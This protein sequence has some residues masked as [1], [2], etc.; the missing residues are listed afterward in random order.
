MEISGAASK[1]NYNAFFTKNENDGNKIFSEILEKKNHSNMS[2]KQ[3]LSTLTP[4]EL[5]TIQKA[6]GLANSIRVNILSGEGAENLFLRP[7]GTDK[8]VDLNNDGVV[9]IGEGKGMF[10]PPPNA[11][12]SVKS[13]WEEATKGMSFGEKSHIM[14]KFRAE[15]LSANFFTGSDGLTH[16]HEIGEAGWQNIFGSTV[17]S[18]LNLF[19]KIIYN[20]D[21]PLAAPDSKQ[22]KIDE[23]VKR[24]L[25]NVIDKIPRRSIYEAAMPK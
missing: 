15:Q 13:A 14:A 8:L 9:E 24:T 2:A 23:F 19:D 7:L 5:Y 12:A 4:N 18:Y 1:Y 10:F 21:H 20:I 17:E 22:R 3:F 25:S 6:N 16:L 11:P